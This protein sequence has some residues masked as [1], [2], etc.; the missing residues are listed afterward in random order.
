MLYLIVDTI[1]IIY[2]YF[3]K[4]STCNGE[5][6][7][8]HVYKCSDG[9]P[10]A[11]RWTCP[12]SAL[13]CPVGACDSD[14]GVVVPVDEPVKGC[15]T[16]CSK[17][18][19]VSLNAPNRDSSAHFDTQGVVEA[20]IDSV[21]IANNNLI[22]S[23]GGDTPT[24]SVTGV[25]PWPASYGSKVMWLYACPSGEGLACLP[26]KYNSSAG[27]NEFVTDI[28]NSNVNFISLICNNSFKLPK[29]L[30]V[31]VPITSGAF[32]KK[33]PVH[34]FPSDFVE[35]PT[36]AGQYQTAIAFTRAQL[37]KIHD[38]GITIVMS[39][40]SWMSDFPR[41][42]DNSAN[43]T[44]ADYVEY[45]DRFECMR[46]SL[47]GALD[48][49]D[50]DIEGTCEGQC[51]WGMTCGC[52]WD[53]GCSADGGMKTA[54]TSNN[55]T[56]YILPDQGTVNVLNGIAKEMKKRGFVC[57]IVPTTTS[58]FSDKKDTYNGQNQFVKY[59]LDFNNIDGVMLQFYTGFDAGICG[60]NYE[61]CKGNNI[62]D[63]STID[64]QYLKN[65]GG[66]DDS[67]KNLPNY[68]NYPNRS[69]EHCPR[70][71]DC[72]DWQ[73]KGEE[74]FQRQVEYFTAL[75][76]IDGLTLD[77]IAFGLEFYFNTSQ[78]GPFPSS[79][80]LYG[81][82]DKLQSS[83]GQELGGVGG[84]TIAGTFGQYTNPHVA[85]VA[86]QG[87]C[88]CD[89]SDYKKQGTGGV[90]GD[91][92]CTGPYYE[93]FETNITSCWGKWGRNN[94]PLKAAS[95]ICTD[96]VPNEW[97]EKKD[98]THVIQCISDGTAPQCSK[99]PPE[100]QWPPSRAI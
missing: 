93:H 91:M 87:L 36:K 4:M 47:G 52:G 72:P 100:N 59:G 13:C 77:K 16:H 32:E 95:T 63:L 50:F 48:G 10:A 43:W 99:S 92:W 71:V 42:S 14:S 84:W 11:G 70:Y 3:I 65:K 49:L 8:A 61:L 25:N 5:C 2:I 76:N 74:P 1:I 67:Y 86:T 51:T 57:T 40:G 20:T 21:S 24:P 83:I 39:V 46:C 28:I 30:G 56:C 29:N 96:A 33:S 73:Y 78:W 26:P 90:E 53:S 94:K 80:L 38:D 45:V 89:R 18:D 17:F 44:D 34:T 98:G 22:I 19:G 79:T 64:L 81:L 27:M 58:F 82:N 41:D 88:N 12:G 75:T 23:Y 31:K 97:C 54:D 7:A 15:E 69:P 60:E 85:P 66:I 35:Y 68:V 9:T 55:Q 62:T 6:C 37:N